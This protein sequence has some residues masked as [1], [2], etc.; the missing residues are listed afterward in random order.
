MRAT[1]SV[2]RSVGPAL[3]GPGRGGR[4]HRERVPDPAAA[5]RPS[6]PLDPGRGAAAPCWGRARAAVPR[7]AVGPRRG[8]RTPLSVGFETGRRL[9]ADRNAQFHDRL[10]SA[11][12]ASAIRGQDPA[13]LHSFF[14]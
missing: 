7:R 10:L 4:L 14:P 11:A 12:A 5:A 3:L 13:G 8:N 2:G 1:R 6:R 9:S